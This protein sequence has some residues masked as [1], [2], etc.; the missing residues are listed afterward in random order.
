MGRMQREKGKRGERQVCDA[1]RPIFGT[2][3]R[4]GVGQA[5]DGSDQADGVGTGPFWIESKHGKRTNAKKALRQAQADCGDRPYWP[6]AVCRDDY[7]EATV[8]MS[9]ADFLD[10]VGEYMELARR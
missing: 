8:T 4:R 10:L 2:G 6:I 7:D 3:V 1:F 5:R 9:L